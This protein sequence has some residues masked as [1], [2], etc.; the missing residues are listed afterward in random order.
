MWAID[1]GAAVYFHHAWTDPD[2]FTAQPYD[3]RDHVLAPYAA[4]VAQADAELA[5]RVTGSLLEE[6]VAL[7]P[8]VWLASDKAHGSVAAT[9]R[10]YVDFLRA[11]VAHRSAWLPEPTR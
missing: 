11:R 6:V 5:P 7:V 8:D 4:R 10:A 1:H 9:R 2:R 3:S